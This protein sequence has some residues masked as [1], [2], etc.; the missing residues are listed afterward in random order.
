MAFGIVAAAAFRFTLRARADREHLETGDAEWIWHTRDIPQPRPVRFYATRDFFLEQAP[1]TATAK[2]FADRRHAFYINGFGMG[3]A[4][5]KPG[6]LLVLYDLTGRLKQGE[7][8]IVIL[9]ESDTG[10]GGLLFALDL[11]GVGRNAIVSDRQWR[12][13]L[14]PDAI[15]RGGRFPA[16]VWGRPPMHPWG[17]PRMPGP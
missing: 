15:E 6:D 9:V 3:N 14:S 16:V 13:D 5:R 4:E 8:R 7:N 2:I 17:Y 1:A 12:V 10:V 11:A